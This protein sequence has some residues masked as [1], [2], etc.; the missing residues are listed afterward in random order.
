VKLFFPV[1]PNKPITTTDEI[2][3]KTDYASFVKQSAILFN[4][5]TDFVEGK[6]SKLAACKDSYY[7]ENNQHHPGGEHIQITEQQKEFPH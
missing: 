3:Q 1:P 7:K 2:R 4:L 6:T 5:M